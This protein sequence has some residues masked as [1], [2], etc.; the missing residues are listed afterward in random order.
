MAHFEQAEIGVSFDLPDDPSA[1]DVLR[2]DSTRL[3]MIGEP[4][5]IILWEAIKPLISEWSCEALPSVYDDLSKVKSLKAAQ[6][7]EYTAIRGSEWRIGLDAV[8]KNS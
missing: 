8:P 6:A 5:L 3:E 2:Y 7:V 4:A 1:L